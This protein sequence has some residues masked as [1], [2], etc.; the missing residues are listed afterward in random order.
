M[1]KKTFSDKKVSKWKFSKLDPIK[2]PHQLR[3]IFIIIAIIAFITIL[4]AGGGGVSAQRPAS[5]N[6]ENPVYLPI[7]VTPMDEEW[8]MLA[9][10]A[11]RTSWSQEEVRGGL[12][13]AWYRPIEP[14]IPYKVQPIAANGKLYIST[15]RGL[16]AFNAGNGAQEWVYPTEVPLGHS[17]TIASVNGRSVAYVGGYDRIIRAIDANT[18]QLVPGYTPY[19][20]GAGFETNPLIVDNIIYAGNRDG[21]FMP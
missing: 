14:Y 11:K 12:N 9:A 3:W 20:A 4:Q 1:I 15:S 5:V 2:A 13:V 19:I 10:N 21:Y 6:A 17:P 8:P 7:I 18:G 16:Y